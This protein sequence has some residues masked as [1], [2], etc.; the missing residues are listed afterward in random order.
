MTDVRPP[1]PMMGCPALAGAAVPS[2]ASLV[3]AD[4]D[5]R[6]VGVMSHLVADRAHRQSREAA[7]AAGAYHH[8]VSV[9]R[10]LDQFVGGHATDAAYGHLLVAVAGSSLLDDF[11]GGFLD[12]FLGLGG[13]VVLSRDTPDA[14]SS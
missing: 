13:R 5:H 14:G 7:S 11:L 6:A 4:D 8:Q 1:R 10:R 12:S 3:V 2:S 9:L